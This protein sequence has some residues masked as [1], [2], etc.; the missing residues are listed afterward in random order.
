M[1]HFELIIMKGFYMSTIKT[2]T[3]D[4]NLTGTAF[5]S[6]SKIAQKFLADFKYAVYKGHPSKWQDVLA[7]WNLPV[8]APNDVI[9]QKFCEMVSELKRVG[10]DMGPGE[11]LYFIE[12]LIIDYDKL[13]AKPGFEWSKKAESLKQF[14]YNKYVVVVNR[15]ERNF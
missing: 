14:I 8:D 4:F 9:E 1:V 2:D 3:N 12:K 11:D 6:Y 10:S 7:R 5:A 13:R 15:R